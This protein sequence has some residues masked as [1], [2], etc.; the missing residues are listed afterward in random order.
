MAKKHRHPKP[1]RQTTTTTSI[2]IPPPKTTSSIAAHPTLGY[3]L[4]VLLHDFL[5][6]TDN[7]NAQRRINAT[8]DEHYISL[9]YF[10]A[11]NASLIKS[12]IVDASGADKEVQGQSFEGAIWII[13]QEFIE[14][15]RASGDARPCG[16]H[17]LAPLY[18]ALFGVQLE[19][20]QADKFLIRLRRQGVDAG[21]K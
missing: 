2:T 8:T 6:L 14:K 9:P 12:A 3:N 5:H 4:R 21:G 7:P 17:H 1:S 20:I 16:P 13:L 19:D 18:A 15:R 11:K 10:T